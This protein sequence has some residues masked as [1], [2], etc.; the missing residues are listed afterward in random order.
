MGVR[1]KKSKPFE[2]IGRPERT[3]EQSLGPG[4]L[5]THKQFGFSAHYLTPPV[6][7][8]FRSG[9]DVHITVHI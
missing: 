8:W 1:K 7:R 6:N 9:Y 3:R 4:D 5:H 2:C